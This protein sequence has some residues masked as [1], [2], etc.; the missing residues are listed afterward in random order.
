MSVQFLVTL[1]VGVVTGVLGNACYHWLKELPAWATDRIHLTGFW[2][3]RVQGYG[4]RLNSIGVIRYD[5]RRAMWVFDG[6]N[7]HNDGRPF[8]HWKTIASYV[9]RAQGRFYYI[10]LNT[11]EEA[12][13]TGYTGF[14]FI[15]LKKEGR[16]WIPSRGSFAAGNPGEA[17][18]SHSMVRL[19]ALP[20]GIEDRLKV[21][22]LL[23]EAS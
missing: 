19:E 8:C 12:G 18:R 5:L 6:T 17:F 14:G 13:H 2:G 9:D 4:E 1:L 7:Y 10:F 15:E 22:N 23:A 20:K 3:E 16:N 11:H 21:F